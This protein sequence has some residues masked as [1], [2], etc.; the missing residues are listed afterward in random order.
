M[1]TPTTYANERE[2]I[3]TAMRLVFAGG[4]SFDESVDCI[5]EYLQRVAEPQPAA[6]GDDGLA[7]CAF[8]R[9][10]AH[11]AGRGGSFYGAC[12]NHDCAA[13]TRSMPSVTEA[14]RV[15][16]TRAT[17]A[18]SA[19][20]QAVEVLREIVTCADLAGFARDGIEAYHTRVKDAWGN[21]RAFL[22]AQP[23]E[24]SK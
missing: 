17:P 12:L 6:V 11:I 14:Q 3:S 23:T 18:P 24:A 1:T 19:P 22:A 21:A 16:N 20:A 9:S 4:L 7:L 5:V 8:C 10:A 15:W 13:T 2:A